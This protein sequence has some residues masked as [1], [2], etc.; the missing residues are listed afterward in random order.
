MKEAQHTKKMNL[1]KQNKELILSSASTN[2]KYTYGN[3]QYGK[4]I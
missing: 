1:W 4:K 2:M 3:T